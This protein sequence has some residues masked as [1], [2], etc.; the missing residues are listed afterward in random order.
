MPCVAAFRPSP[1]TYYL[2]SGNGDGP[3]TL[4]AFDADAGT[5]AVVPLDSI[6]AVS[7]LAWDASRGEL[8]GVGG[9]DFRAPY[10][11][12]S[13]DASTGKTAPIAP[14]NGTLMAEVKPCEQALATRPVFNGTR[15][16][17]AALASAA[18]DGPERVQGFDVD[19]GAVTSDVEWPASDGL[20]S[21]ITVVA[22]PGAR[23]EATDVLLAWVVDPDF[24]QPLTLVAVDPHAPGAAAPRVVATVPTPAGGSGSTLVPDRL[25]WDGADG[26]AAL[27]WD[28]GAELQFLA[29][30]NISA[31]WAGGPL[32]VPAAAVTTVPVNWTAN[33]GQMY[34][35][36][37][38]SSGERR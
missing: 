36:V 11:V 23:G 24:A 34:H 28:N 8:L 35:L 3:S 5:A 26:V 1:P 29:T 32:P 19:A 30:V 6:W 31:Y 13:I 14:L 17:A 18:D 27:A 12:F 7:A 15:L 38:A 9:P 25:A 2:L 10:T 16:Y 37:Y 22:P 20:L 33:G 21:A 4:H